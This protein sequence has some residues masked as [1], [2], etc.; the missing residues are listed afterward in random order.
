MFL[1]LAPVAIGTN[2]NSP[3]TQ[4]GP[5]KSWDPK[6]SQ[7]FVVGVLNWKS[8]SLESFTAKNRRDAQLLQAFINAGVPKEQT[9]YLSDSN[10]TLP[11]IFSALRASLKNCGPNDTYVFYYCGHG[12]LDEKGKGY[13]ANYDVGASNKECLSVDKIVKEFDTYF[14]GSQAIFL[15]DCC[16]SGVIADAL[17]SSKFKY[18]VLTAATSEQDSTSNW[19][20]T[21]SVVDAINGHC[22][23]DKNKDGKITFDELGKYCTDEMK[24]IEGQNATFSCGNTFDPALIVADVKSKAETT[25][26]RVAVKYDGAWWLAKLLETKNGKGKV[27]WLEIGW[28]APS[29][30][31]WVDLSTVKSIEQKAS[32]EQKQLKKGDKVLVLSEGRYYDSVIRKVDKDKY[33]I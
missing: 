29:D 32:T 33:F 24:V 22:Y 16:R 13:F 27:H 18:A 1:F 21:Q 2:E 20:F 30:D 26:K 23:A 17:K 8:G 6:H 7:V 9:K 25:P 19:T 11:A 14:K 28:D 3:T 12:W 4:L 31:E 15:A 10:A 5:G